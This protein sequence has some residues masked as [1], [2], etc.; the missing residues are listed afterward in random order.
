MHPASGIRDEMLDYMVTPWLRPATGLPDS[1]LYRVADA[2]IEQLGELSLD[3]VRL[4]V[5][6][7]RR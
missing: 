4:N 5:I 6:A 7:R 2:A 3:Y 1:E